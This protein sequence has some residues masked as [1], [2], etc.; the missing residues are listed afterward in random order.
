M[1]RKTW[2]A[3]W[4][5]RE[6]QRV[7]SSPDGEIAALVPRLKEEGV[8]RALDIGCGLGRHVVLMAASGFETYALDSS[9]YAVEHCRARLD[10]EGLHASV[11]HSDMG[12]LP[13]PDEF[14][15]FVLCWDVIYHARRQRMVEV[16]AEVKRILR[17][18]GLLY[19]TLNSTRN[20]HYGGGTE[21]E[22]NTFDD[23]GKEDGCHLHHYSDESDVGDL[24][25][26]WRAESVKESEQAL[27][28]EVAPGSW[29]WMILARKAV[30]GR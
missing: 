17:K 14:F 16:L 25:A 9:E 23:P 20:E 10:G 21:V 24:L 19:L 5:G 13:Y 28:G 15:G 12:A 7:W 29:H 22:P 27:D 1:K 4:R 26:G 11:V 3:L 6:K 2:D 30:G 8:R 18:D